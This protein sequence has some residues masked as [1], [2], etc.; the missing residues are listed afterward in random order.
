MLASQ[1]V[2]LEIALNRLTQLGMQLTY[3]AC[4]RCAVVV[5]HSLLFLNVKMPDYI[6]YLSLP[7]QYTANHL[8]EDARS[9]SH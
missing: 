6:G 8:L 1:V 7:D 3:G 2:L 4:A 9:P 5:A